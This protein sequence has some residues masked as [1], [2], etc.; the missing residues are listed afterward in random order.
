M[1][2]RSELKQQAKISM[3]GRK[4]SV[5]LVTLAYTL[6]IYVI[7]LL[8][9]K[10]QYVNLNMEELM[11]VMSGELTYLPSMVQPSVTGELIS[12]ALNF[13]TIIMGVG[14]TIYALRV[15][16]GDKKA[17]FGDLFDGFGMFFKFIWLNMLMGIFVFLWSMLFIIPGIIAAFR[18]SMAIYIM[19]D[20]PEYSALECIRISKEMMQGH[21]LELFI[22]ELSFLGW[23]LLC[24]IP[25]V[26]VYVTPYME[27]T[28]ANY[29]NALSGYRPEVE[30][31][32]YEDYKEPWEQ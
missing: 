5:Y 13:M 7:D 25:F 6:I 3:K 16:R 12:I 20:N 9:T 26:G 11:A 27:T 23:T 22:L 31:T 14:F 2:S 17:G 1:P 18:Y 30:Y 24:L 4:P 21:K 15:S 28:F 19:I 10:I 29:Y 32:V 8:S